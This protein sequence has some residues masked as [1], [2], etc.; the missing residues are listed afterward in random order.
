[1][2]EMLAAL[3]GAI[4]GGVLS[5]W[6]G[7]RQT[8]KVLKPQAD[9]ATTERQEAQRV[10]GDRRRSS[11]AD[12]LIVALADFMTVRRG[13]R[14][15]SASFVRVPATADVHQDRNDRASALLQAGSSYAHAARCDRDGPLVSGPAT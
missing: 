11:A 10:D 4:V 13:D 1:M 14:H 9:L 8:G 7:S 15:R 3:L 6:V 2:T 5:A 12:R